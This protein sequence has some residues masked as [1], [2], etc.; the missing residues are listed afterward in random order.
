LVF[1]VVDDT[2]HDLIG[3]ACMRIQER[4]VSDFLGKE[5][6][7]KVERIKN[8]FNDEEDSAKK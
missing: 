3:T 4:N 7:L 2:K 5:E 1:F 6:D 8:P